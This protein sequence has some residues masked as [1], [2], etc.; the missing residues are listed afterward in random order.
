MT[1][2]ATAVALVGVLVVGCGPSSGMGPHSS[3]GT[4]GSVTLGSSDSIGASESGL[5]ATTSDDCSEVHEGTLTIDQDTDVVGLDTIGRINGGLVVER[6]TL[7]DLSILSCVR[8]VHGSVSI[9]DNTE[10]TSLSGLER[11]EL[12]EV[13]GEPA[14][15]F[16]WNPK[17][18]SLAGIGPIRSLD[19]LVLG[20][21]PALRDLALNDLESVEW[22]EIGNCVSDGTRL[23]DESI[24]EI[25]GLASLQSINGVFIGGL[26][27]L[28]SLGRLHEIPASGW[29]GF[30]SVY[31]YNNP[32]LPYAEVEALAEVTAEAGKLTEGCGN[33]DYPIPACPECPDQSG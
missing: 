1:S 27:D 19:R 20:H 33:P 14:S 23:V 28:V 13:E 16:L 12:V 29:H 5:A 7:T 31:L 8:E 6:T 32:S 24:V 17:L 3:D 25:N 11:L 4:A 2:S 9:V 26:R 22:L 10:L 15:L 18:E 21:N 30:G